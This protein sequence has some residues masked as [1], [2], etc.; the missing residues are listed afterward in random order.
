MTVNIYQTPILLKGYH[1][2]YNKDKDY[3]TAKTPAPTSKGWTSPNY[4]PPTPEEIEA[5]VESGGWVGYLVPQG[6]HVIDVEDPAKIAEIVRLL[7][8]KKIICP[9]NKTNKGMHFIFSMNGGPPFTGNSARLTRM[10][11]SI[12]DR[13]AGKNYV[14]LPPT[15]DREW[16]NESALDNPPIIPDELCPPK[17]DNIEDLLR[18]LA[19]SLGDTYRRGFLAGYDDLDNAFMALLAECHIPEALI[20]E[21]FRLLFLDSF[22]ERRTLVMHNRVTERL[23]FDQPLRGTGSLVETL[24]QKNLTHEIGLISRLQRLTQSLAPKKGRV[25]KATRA[26]EIA[27]SEYELFHDKDNEAFATFITGDRSETCRVSSKVFKSRLAKD[28]WARYGGGLG[29]KDINDAIITIEGKAQN[30]GPCCP[31]YIRIAVLD[32]A[33]Y[34]DIGDENRTVI[35][36]TAFGWCVD[37]ECKIK[38]LQPPG[39]AALPYPEKGGSINTLMKYVNLED[40]QDWCLLVAFIIGCFHPF[41]PYPGLEVTGEQGSA[42]STLLRVILALVDPSTTAPRVVPRSIDDL[43]IS[44][45]NSWIICFDNVSIISEWLSDALCRLSTGGGFATRT[46]YSNRDETLF[47][48]KRPLMFNCIEYAIRRSDLIDRIISINLKTI[49]DDERIPENKFWEEFNRDAPGILGAFLDAV[50]CA[51]KNY[52]N[53]KLQSL[54]RMADFAIWVVAAESAL[55]WEPGTF[56]KEYAR[57]RRETISLAV[58]SS[59]ILTGVRDLIKNIYPE[60]WTSTMG[61]LLSVLNTYADKEKRQN[62]WW[63]TTPNHLSGALKRGAPA[64]RQEGIEVDLSRK[65]NTGRMVS[66]KPLSSGVTMVTLSDAAKPIQRHLKYSEDTNSSDEE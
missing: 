43:A 15:N 47:Y 66:L 64:L 6:V 38:F 26:I 52:K 18:E 20:L 42:K 1:P 3:K 34:V 11:F 5:W 7:Q 58:E 28:Y 60:G 13:S 2:A 59:P 21:T 27:F 33:I 17:K 9:I 4:K 39:M 57:N 49:P 24:K 31:V 46:L 50:S 12:T 51:L 45:S 8:Q 23:L 22:D 32:D 29:S 30:D 53:T 16:A 65:L 14:I 54:P 48:A 19:W 44:A 40:M 36:I 41:G 10:G 61:E 35:K 56:I 62:K 25:S 55:G 63:P 37:T